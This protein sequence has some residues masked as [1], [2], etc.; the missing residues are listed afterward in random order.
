MG[1]NFLVCVCSFFSF[2]A[3]SRPEK[4]KKERFNFLDLGF[5][6]II[7]IWKSPISDYW[8]FFF[9]A[10]ELFNNLSQLVGQVKVD[11]L[12]SPFVRI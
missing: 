10:D 9:L 4:N 6:F 2:I 1:F 3:T 8:P 5:F 11:Q 7:L 12:R